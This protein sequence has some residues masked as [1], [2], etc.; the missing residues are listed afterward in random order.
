MV[1]PPELPDKYIALEGDGLGVLRYVST[2]VVI[3]NAE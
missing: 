1:A 3:H 2:R